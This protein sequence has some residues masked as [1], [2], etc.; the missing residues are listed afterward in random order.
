MLHAT[1][2]DF[3]SANHYMKPC[4]LLFRFLPRDP[5]REYIYVFQYYYVDSLRCVRMVLSLSQFLALI[6]TILINWCRGNCHSTLSPWQLHCQ[7]V[8][9][10]KFDCSFQFHKSFHLLYSF[11]L[12]PH[13]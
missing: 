11:V 3:L 9:F 13:L 7:T 10:Q 6:S 4:T 12:L 2:L 5:L 1:E 8:A